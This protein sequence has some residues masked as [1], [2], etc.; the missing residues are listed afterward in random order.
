MPNEISRLARPRLRPARCRGSKSGWGSIGWV[1]RP[2]SQRDRNLL[3]VKSL[4]TSSRTAGSGW[5]FALCM[6][7]QLAWQ[8]DNFTGSPVPLIESLK[9]KTHLITDVRKRKNLTHLRRVSLFKDSSALGALPRIKLLWTP[10]ADFVYG[11]DPSA[12]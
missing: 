9:S 7:V 8:S 12:P 4:G 11:L 2:R 1:K 6:D 3:R 10:L 5:F